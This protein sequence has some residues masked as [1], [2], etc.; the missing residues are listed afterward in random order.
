MAEP[1]TH[2]DILSAFDQ[3]KPVIQ[4]GGATAHELADAAGLHVQCVRRK[5]AQALAAGLLE[6][7]HE[8]RQRI[9]GRSQMTSVY[10]AVKPAKRGKVRAS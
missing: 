6:L 7:A 3:C 5:I 4:G 1:I 2:A 10:R 9:D 8:P